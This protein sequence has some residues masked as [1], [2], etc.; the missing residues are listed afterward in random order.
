MSFLTAVQKQP[1]S[2]AMIYPQSLLAWGIVETG[3]STTVLWTQ[4]SKLERRLRHVPRLRF[5][6]RDEF[7]FYLTPS[8]LLRL[9]SKISGGS[10]TC[11]PQP[12]LI[13]LQKMQHVRIILN[14]PPS[15]S[16]SPN[17][18]DES[19]CV[20]PDLF[21]TFLKSVHARPPAPKMQHQ[22]PNVFLAVQKYPNTP[23]IKKPTRKTSL[24][25]NTRAFIAHPGA[26]YFFFSTNTSLRASQKRKAGKKWH[27][28]CA[29]FKKLTIYDSLVL[30]FS[31]VQN[32]NKI[33]VTAII[34][35][36]PAGKDEYHQ[37]PMSSLVRHTVVIYM[38]QKHHKSEKYEG[39]DGED[40]K[41]SKLIRDRYRTKRKKR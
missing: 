36:R 38:H 41:R 21:P 10:V 29:C 40:E 23:S 14:S 24:L 32:K 31:T 16:H 13:N 1:D 7:D 19:Q 34:C 4:N 28:P 9:F 6:A 22:P 17:T 30:S 25:H 18:S 3:P 2:A 15:P 11:R 37:D 35:S 5:A 8:S 26:E 39:V 12:C 33:V 20:C 27:T